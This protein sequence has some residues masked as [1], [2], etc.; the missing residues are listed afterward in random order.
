MKKKLIYIIPILILFGCTIRISDFVLQNY[1]IA[2]EDSVFVGEPIITWGSGKIYTP[3]STKVLHR[4]R[5]L[6]EL[7][8]FSARVGYARELV[9]L[10]TNRSGVLRCM[11]REYYI[12]TQSSILKPG[13]SLDLEYDLSESMTIG[14]QGFEIE[15]IRA[16]QRMVLYR[17]VKEP[18][19]I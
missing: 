16:D 8:R 17:V 12:D 19:D 18:A 6:S 3:G 15:I 14:I 11:F 7:I 5:D 4:V 10:G 9:Y 13:F 2:K 1:E